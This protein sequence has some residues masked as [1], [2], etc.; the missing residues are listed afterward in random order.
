MAPAP[1]HLDLPFDL[2][3]PIDV[4]HLILLHLHHMQDICVLALLSV[5]RLLKLL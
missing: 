2:E 5:L 1:W 3:Q 4:P